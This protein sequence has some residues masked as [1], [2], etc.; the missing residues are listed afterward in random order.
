[1]K[2]EYIDVWTLNEFEIYDL[3]I[4]SGACVRRL[5]EVVVTL[6]IYCDLSIVFCWFLAVI[7]HGRTEAVHHSTEYRLKV[8]ARYE[9]GYYILVNF[10]AYFI[11]IIIISEFH[12]SVAHLACCVRNNIILD[13]SLDSWTKNRHMQLNAV[14]YLQVGNWK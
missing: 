3:Y 4:Q 11:S 12:C 1:M 5:D 2:G 8:N 9:S 13:F 14:K 6:A 7:V 10:T